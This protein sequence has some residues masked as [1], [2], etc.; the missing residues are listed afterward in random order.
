MVETEKQCKPLFKFAA[1]RSRRN[2]LVLHSPLE[3]ER[4]QR[5]DAT[6][7]KFD[8]AQALALIKFVVE[9]PIDRS[10]DLTTCAGTTVRA[11]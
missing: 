3:E 1:Q 5:F 11:Q 2:V 6:D 8:E 10:L 7:A 9:P 4:Q